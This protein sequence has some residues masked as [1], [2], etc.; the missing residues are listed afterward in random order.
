[1]S[2]QAVQ[3]PGGPQADVI[4][5]AHHRDAPFVPLFLFAWRDYIRSPWAW[6]NLVVLMAVQ[7]IFLSNPPT[8]E[9]FFG[10]SY[11]TVLLLGALNSAAIFS[12]ADHPQTTAILV[13]PISRAAYVGALWLVA[14][15]VTLAGY[16][17]TL[18]AIVLRHGPPLHGIN[19]VN[20]WM[21]NLL[22]FVTGSLPMIAGAGLAVS[23]LAL[24]SNFV[25]PFGLRLVVLAIVALMVMS[26]DARNFLIEQLRPVVQYLPPFVAPVAGALRFATDQTLEPL[27]VVSLVMVSAYAVALLAIVLWLTA[28][29]E[30]RSEE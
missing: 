23:L 3:H 25:A 7:F 29:R 22:V 26:F 1:V 2:L 21:Q 11:L 15:L 18:V 8:R 19:P 14:L 13:R 5:P 24:L 30:N 6:A 27:S 10:T 20:E 9:E 17:A 12:R 28:R 16:L 4:L